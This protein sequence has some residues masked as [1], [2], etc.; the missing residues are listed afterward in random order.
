MV[1]GDIATSPLYTVQEFFVP[2]HGVEPSPTNIVGL[3]SLVLWSLILVVTVKYVF[4]LMRADN[5]G[6]GGIMALL[7][8]VPERL[9]KTR[10]KHIPA[11][12]LMVILGASLLFGDGVIT[13]AI[14]VLSAIE[15]LAVARPD[16]KSYVVPITCLIL[17]FLFL[18]QRRGTGRLSSWFGPILL[19]WLLVAGSLGLF[20]LWQAPE[21]L[22]AFLPTHGLGFLWSHGGHGFLLLGSVVLAVTGGEALYADMGH[23]GRRPIRHAWLYVALPCLM[24][25]YLGQGALLLHHPEFSGKIFYSMVPQ[26]FWTFALCCLA[27]PATVIASQALISATFSLTHQAVRLGFLPRVLVLQT[28]ARFRGQVYVPLVNWALALSCLSL[29]LLFRE[30]AR[31][32]AAFGLAV[33]G[34]MALTSGVFYCVSRYRWNWPAWKSGLVLAAFLTLDIPFLAAT[35]AKFFQGG[36]IPVLIAAVLFATMVTWLVGRSLLLEF[37]QARTVPLDKFLQRIAREIPTRR[38]GLCVVMASP[39]TGE[40]PPVLL[41]LVNRFGALHENVFLLTVTSGRSLRAPGR[42][43]RDRASRPGNLPRHLALWLQR[44]APGHAG[45]AP[46]LSQA[47][48]LRA[49][50]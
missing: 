22:W 17:A 2:V 48:A 15:G 23:F 14:S 12:A 43:G 4:I 9:R 3:I 19:L 36:Y 40:T 10:G 25:S 30:S 27:T 20:H 33:S 34:T 1:F 18:L 11:V 8:L 46:G 35:S 32:A 5:R 41:N 28:S 37:Y 26:G 7:A 47:A 38:P 16:L 50:Q 39:G 24:L 42:G 29:V 44:A 6:E 49:G 31:L 21:I 13:P 45:S